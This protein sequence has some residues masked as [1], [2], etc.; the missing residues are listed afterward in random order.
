MTPRERAERAYGVYSE[1]WVAH[2]YGGWL[3]TDKAGGQLVGHCELEYLPETDEVELG[4]AL[5]KAY[6][7]K[8]IATEAARAV[9]RFGFERAKLERIMAVV[10]PENTASWRVLE[11]IGFVYEKK[12]NYYDLEIVYYA[13]SR[14][15][16][17]PGDYFFQVHEE[18]H[19]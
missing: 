1:L 4:Y 13:I 12:A 11:H 15:Q 19:K 9:V 10:V 7:G 16:F 14:E 5:A 8:G 3:I 2:P 17:I 18:S 6:W